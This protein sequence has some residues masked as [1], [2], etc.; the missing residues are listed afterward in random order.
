MRNQCTNSNSHALFFLEV[1]TAPFSPVI[2]HITGIDDILS[3][4]WIAQTFT[5]RL[6]SLNIRLNRYFKLPIKRTEL[7]NNKT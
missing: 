1:Q 6:H 3:C 4:T 5:Y 7:H 2:K